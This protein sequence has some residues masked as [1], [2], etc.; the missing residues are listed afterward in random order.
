[1]ERS[2][3]FSS[4]VLWRWG[5]APACSTGSWQLVP[6]LQQGEGM[7][8]WVCGRGCGISRA[9][10]QAPSLT[11]AAAF[12][13]PGPAPHPRPQSC[14]VANPRHK[15]L[16]PQNKAI[17][18]GSLAGSREEKGRCSHG[19]YFLLPGSTRISQTFPGEYQ[20]AL[21]S[22]GHRAG[23][24]AVLGGRTRGDISITIAL[25]LISR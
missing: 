23:D 1:M 24:A 18:L 22:Q 14:R 7:W 20:V 21:P 5:L 3:G 12:G 6:A 11:C 25:P 16:K 19:N 13:T 8:H 4:V 10:R 17:K 2:C 15:S 9:L